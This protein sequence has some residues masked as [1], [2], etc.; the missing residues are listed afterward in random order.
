[1]QEACRDGRTKCQSGADGYGKRVEDLPAGGICRNRAATGSAGGGRACFWENTESNSR[2]ESAAAGR[3]YEKMVSGSILW[4]TGGKKRSVGGLSSERWKKNRSEVVPEGIPGSKKA[5]L[6]YEVL[7]WKDCMGLAQ[8]R[9]LTGR[10]H[11]IRVQMAEHGMPLAGDG[12]YGA[13]ALESRSAYQMDRRENSLGL[14]A[15]RLEFCHPKTGKEL[16]FQIKPE[17]KCFLYF[18]ETVSIDKR[19]EWIL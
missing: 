1:M 19:T 12:K 10:H 18:E 3:N 4:K 7:Q 14:C 8:I 16:C 5:V 15:C 6:N 13:K 9:L 2:A 11:Q 17:G